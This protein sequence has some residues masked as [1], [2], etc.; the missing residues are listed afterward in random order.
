MMLVKKNNNSELGRIEEL[1]ELKKLEKID[2]NSQITMRGS[3]I[4][5]CCYHEYKF[6]A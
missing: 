4:F 6:A 1:T 3:A 5:T 2:K